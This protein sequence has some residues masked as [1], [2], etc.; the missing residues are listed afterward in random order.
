M[1]TK[2]LFNDKEYTDI[3]ELMSDIDDYIDADEI[4]DNM[5]DECYEDIDICGGDYAPSIALHRVDECAYNCGRNDYMSGVLSD[6]RYDIE[7]LSDGE[8]Y[9]NY[10]IEVECIEEYDENEDDE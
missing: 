4:Y 3:D 5:L 1:T 10:D 8:T 9:D 2:Y 6:M 7:R